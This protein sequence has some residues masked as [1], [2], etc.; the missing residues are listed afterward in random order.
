MLSLRRHVIMSLILAFFLIVCYV[1]PTLAAS[2][3]KPLRLRKQNLLTISLQDHQ[4]QQLPITHYLALGDSL[5]YG[6]QPNDD[7]THGYVDDLFTAL[8]SQGVTSHVNLGCPGETTSTFIS[9]GKCS[10]P[11]KSQLAAA[12][13][14][15]H[16]V[17]TGLASLVT[18]DIGANDMLGHMNINVQNKVC[19]VDMNLFRTDLQTMDQ[20]LTQTILPQLHAALIDNSGQSTGNLV[21]LNYYDPFQ[22]TCPNTLL[23]IQ[24]LNEHLAHDM[25][26]FGTLVD[27]FGAFGG[28]TTPNTN[29]CSY[30]WMCSAPPL[31]PDMHPTTK[32]YQ[33]IENAID[34]QN[35][36]QVKSNADGH[37]DGDKTV[38]NVR[39]N[40]DLFNLLNE[41]V[42]CQGE[43]SCR[44][45]K[46]D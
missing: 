26:G 36:L 7:H 19:T 14:D 31:G 44:G 21:L 43:H 12:L 37:Q 17:P 6:F 4:S 20:N 28:S 5:A 1:S 22:N 10:Y 41:L 2:Y 34:C 46:D 13:A 25:Q 9:G 27:I 3:D 32:G 30:T 38:K 11:L 29:L 16:Q 18:L 24:T 33:V 45:S 15:L 23:P 42:G 35:L 8:Q 39:D 40:S